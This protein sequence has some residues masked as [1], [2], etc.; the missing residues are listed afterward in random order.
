VEAHDE[1]LHREDGVEVERYEEL[2]RVALGGDASGWRLGLAVLEHK[3][4][5]AWMRWRS[6]GPRREPS[7]TSAS[8]ARSDEL[9]GVLASMALACLGEG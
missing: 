6:T 5:A 1:V 8:H 9:V 2:R 4:V 3:G 7:T